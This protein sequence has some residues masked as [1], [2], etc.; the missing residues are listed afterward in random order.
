MLLVEEGPLPDIF[1]SGIGRIEKL[2]CGMARV[3]FYTERRLDDGQIERVAV[4][5]LVRPISTWHES[6]KMMTRAIAATDAVLVADAYAV[7][8]LLN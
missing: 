1:V 8:S 7:A 2:A 5:R 6:I 4:C 3:I